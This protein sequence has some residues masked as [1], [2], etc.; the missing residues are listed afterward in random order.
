[1]IFLESIDRE[2][3]VDI[4]IGGFDPEQK[5]HNQIT[6]RNSE[7]GA[8][9]TISTDRPVIRFRLYADDRVVSPRPVV[10]IR[11]RPARVTEWNTVYRFFE[12]R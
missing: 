10:F 3:P 5:S 11:N 8:G 2:S 4:E 7:T 1:V 6:V 9:V 12:E